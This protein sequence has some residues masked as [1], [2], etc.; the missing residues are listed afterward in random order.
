MAKAAVVNMPAR[1]RV[2]AVLFEAG[3]GF[4]SVLIGVNL[5]VITGEEFRTLFIALVFHQFFEGIAVGSTVVGNYG[6]DKSVLA[7]V[8]A[9]TLCTPIGIVIGILVS[10]SYNESSSRSLWTQ[11]TLDAVSAGILLYT[12][13]VELMTYQV[14]MSAD[15]ARQSVP[16]KAAAFLCMYAGASA[17]AM[18]GRWA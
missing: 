2:A 11:G 16:R 13:L 12:G 3:V 8:L 18:V 10:G 17:M 14:T 6:T 15:L 4:H 1:A 5:G 7:M 9:Y